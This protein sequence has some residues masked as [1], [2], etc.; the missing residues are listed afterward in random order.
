MA[1]RA[2]GA[3]RRLA[4]AAGTALLVALAAGPGAA[5]AD[6]GASGRWITY[7][8]GRVFLP[9]GLNLVVTRPPYSATWF[10]EQDARFIASQG[11]TAM[12][13][14]IL[15]QAIEPEL[16]R[17]DSAYLQRFIARQ[18]Q[19][20]RYG[21]AS[22]VALNQ[23]GYAEACGGDG[24][25]AWALLAPCDDPWA[26]FWANA[27][28][29]DTVG[30]QGHYRSWVTE[31]GRR[32]AGARGLLGLDLLNEPKAPDDG[33]VGALWRATL[34]TVRAAAPGRL[35][36][37]EPRDPAA[38]AFGGGVPAGTGL[39][40]H[41]YCAS[42]LAKGLAGVT[43]GRAEIDACI[44]SDAATLAAQVS[45]AR[46]SGLPVLVGEFGAT[47]DRPARRERGAAAV[48]AARRPPARLGGER[49]GGEAGRA[50]RP[51]SGRGRRDTP[52]VALRPR[53]AH[54]RLLLLDRPGR[55]RQV[56]RAAADGAV[57]AAPRLPARLRRHGHG[58]H[59]RLRAGSA[60][61]AGRRG[62]RRAARAGR[63]GAARRNA[64]AQPDRG[65][66]LRVRPGALRPTIGRVPSPTLTVTCMT[67]GPGPRVAALLGLLRPLAQEIVVAL[68]DRADAETEGALAA[69]A[70]R[71]VRYAYREPV[72][73]PV[74]WLHSLASGDWILNLDDDEVPGAALLAELP[75]LV[76]ATDVTHYWIRR[77]WLWPDG[78]SVIAEQP[79]SS[80]YQLRLVLNDPRLLR[81][82]S[83]THRPI[84]AIGPHRYVRAPLY[85]ADALLN[86]LERREAKARKYEALRPGKRVGGGPMNHVLHLPERRAGLQVEPLP[87]EDVELVRAVLEAA[88][89]GVP[90]QTRA[91]TVDDERIEA[92]WSGRAFAD[93][94]YRARISFLEEPRR[95]L[96]G[97]QRTFDI[98]VENLG[99]TTWPWGEQGEPEVRV[100][101]RWLDEHGADLADGIRTSFPADVVPGSAVELPLHV[102]APSAPG[103]YRIAVD[104]VH[105]RVRW[106]GS[107]VEQPV[108]VER[109]LRLAIVGADD[110]VLAR[111]AE[112]APSVQPL[113]LASTP[114]PLYGPPRAPDLRAYLLEGT[115][116]GRLR[117]FPLLAA[118]TATLLRAARRLRAG[119]PVRP[120]LRGGQEFLDALAG[121]THLLVVGE[122]ERGIRERWLRRA[123]V[124][125]AQALDVERVEHLD[126]SEVG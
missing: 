58:R 94:D 19:L 99:G 111:L 7:P 121:S 55:R 68:D 44:G 116:H 74:R 113:V 83:E 48:A 13:L 104:L 29:A 115:T 43:P 38:P 4:A 84:E 71:L 32:F 18:A 34:P 65:A 52:V 3:A 73:R 62:A 87:P 89:P 54:G 39:A 98:R 61:A 92:L 46:R 16:G 107:P 37:V 12:R 42:T 109:P 123:T 117:D 80:D 20:A 24:F 63:A 77:P 2:S 25:P 49:E 112:E 69:V 100:S 85:H 21:I 36:F 57:R 45:L 125:A 10:S 40:G 93:E 8:D 66:P 101:Y 120:L 114:G 59:R 95:L 14:A 124:A 50:R 17:V 28:A 47:D 30:L 96:A 108:D 23:D 70:D 53:E 122:A 26:P 86:P 9:H 91:A 5:A 56:H 90:A 60:V 81:F 105:E 126:G 31:V 118:R 82:P 15:P 6:F 67:G 103:R 22:L 76:R 1:S 102:L 64:H 119:E 78:G 79:W 97:E 72:D 110:D 33:V 27:P 41:V 51:V 88:G 106:F 11:F 35:A 75:A